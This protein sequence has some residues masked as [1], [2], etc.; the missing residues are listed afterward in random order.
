MLA[1]QD[2]FLFFSFRFFFFSC[3]SVS[4]FIEKD[5]FLKFAALYIVSGTRIFAPLRVKAC[6]QGTGL[7]IQVFLRSCSSS[8][9]D[10]ESKV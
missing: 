5:S 3:H 9:R 8:P 2:S 4:C 1:K 10:L 7:A 6:E